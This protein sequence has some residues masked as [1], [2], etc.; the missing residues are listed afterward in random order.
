MEQ[1]LHVT[2]ADSPLPLACGFWPQPNPI[3]AS[4]TID[5]QVIVSNPSEDK[6]VEIENMVIQFPIGQDTAAKLSSD[7]KL[8]APVL[9]TPGAWEVKRDEDNTVLI[10]PAGS[11][12][13]IVFGGEPLIFRLP[14]IRVNTKAGKVE[15]NIYETVIASGGGTSMVDGKASLEKQPS[16]FTVESFSAQP[17]IVNDLGEEVLLK[18]NCT[19]EDANRSFRLRGPGLSDT[20][21]TCAQGRN[22]IRVK[23]QGNT[24][25][26]LEVLRGDDLQQT[27]YTHVEVAKVSL[28]SDYHLKAS[29][30][31]RMLRIGW[32]ARNAVKCV[33]MVNSVPFDRN[34][35][36]DTY[37]EESYYK[38]LLSGENGP[39]PQ[40]TVEAEGISGAK[41]SRAITNTYEIT[42]PVSLQISGQY[43]KV[44][45]SPNGRYALLI[46]A[47]I[48][49]AE[50]IVVADLVNLS[51]P[52]KR[53]EVATT[54]ADFSS[55][56]EWVLIST[57]DTLIRVDLA[58]GN[59]VWTINSPIPN[60]PLFG[61]IALADD[62]RAFVVTGGMAVTEIELPSG[63]ILG[64]HPFSLA[65][66]GFHHMALS[67]DRKRIAV[68]RLFYDQQVRNGIPGIP[69]MR[70]DLH[71]IDLSKTPTVTKQVY[72]SD[73]LVGGFSMTPDARVAV[74]VEHVIHSQSV[75]QRVS[76]IDLNSGQVDRIPLEADGFGA[77]ILPNGREAIIATTEGLKLVDVTKKT[78]KHWGLVHGRV[79]AI[80][81]THFAVVAGH[82]GVFMI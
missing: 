42:S 40:L 20:R 45:I 67:A 25:Y 76:I 62:N 81:P 44:R 15:I 10:Q 5:L 30:S 9:V 74:A 64:I 29:P 12:E 51:A 19:S 39:G 28:W 60:V 57:G 21:Y 77:A 82:S 7:S 3:L 70:S 66:S 56:G 17:A 69:T 72:V 31:G 38:L 4:T 24:D 50:G 63:K 8:P 65:P 46:E 79:V 80:S 73:A 13:K 52:K 55:N 34:A 47:A 33:L 36:T 18:W 59:R 78:M 54:D 58:T 37:S 48:A 49:R 2:A 32:R 61:I 22:G 43:N 14:G 1:L 53:I 68:T 41:T 6:T 11:A 27:F 16:D 75:E 71:L 35:P 26:K 23:V